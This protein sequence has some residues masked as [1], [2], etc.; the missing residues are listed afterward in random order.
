IYYTLATVLKDYLALQNVDLYN[1]IPYSQAFKGSEAVFYPK[2]DDPKEVY[3]SVINELKQI[4]TDLPG[5]YNGMTQL[6]KDLVAK[7]DVALGGSVDK[8]LMFINAIRLKYAIRI[9]G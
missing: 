2:F 3:V 4:Y 8:W 1:S 6:G 5:V 7:Y 9:S